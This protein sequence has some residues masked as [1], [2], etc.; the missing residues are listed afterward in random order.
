MLDTLDDAD[1]GRASGT[2]IGS[3]VLIV[4]AGMA[5]SAAALLLDRQGIR[6]TVVDPNAVYPQ[7]FRCEKLTAG[8]L[9]LVERLGLAECLRDAGRTV[10]EALVARSGRVIERR[11]SAELCLSYED[12]VNA[13]RRAWP[14]NIRFLQ[15]KVAS[16]ATSGA[17]QRAQL[18]SG[19]TVEARL[20]I[21]ATGPSDKLRAQ[22]NMRR[23]RIDH[24]SLCIGMNLA[25]AQ[26]AAF[27][28]EALTYFGEKA[29]DGMAF[30]AFFPMA[31]QLRLNLFCYRRTDEPWTD[32]LRARPL[33]AI[34]RAM[35]GLRALLG[36]AVVLGKPQVHATQLFAVE[37]YLQDGVVLAG[38]AFRPSCPVTGSGVTRVLT[39]VGRLCNVHIPAWLASDGMPAQKIA[40]FYDDP[41]KRSADEIAA[42]QAARARAMANET[43]MRWRLRRQAVSAAG[44]LRGLVQRAA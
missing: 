34:Y 6:V 15:D 16:L 20:V 12:M 24:R 8:Q 2:R 4:G 1:R 40:A 29:G 44:R 22:L 36:D 42:R 30:G 23:K 41:V 21:L 31:D 14:Q 27:P 7:D 39:D 25:P 35:P 37:G 3:D 5:G 11:R 19:A 38:E 17:L 26:G 13:V 28:F 43:G 33:T 18:S 10:R 9:E 32:L